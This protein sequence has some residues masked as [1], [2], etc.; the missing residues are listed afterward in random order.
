MQKGL[1][2]ENIT[3]IDS[4]FFDQE[5]GIVGETYIVDMHLYGQLN[6]EDMI[7][8][9][10]TIK[11]DAK[12]FID[13]HLDHLF[14]V[15]KQNKHIKVQQHPSHYEVHG[16]YGP[17]DKKHKKLHY[18]APHAALTLIDS[19]HISPESLVDYL[20]QNLT[21]QLPK[22]IQKVC[23][24]LRYEAIPGPYFRYSHGLRNHQ[25]NC[26][27]LIHGHRSKMLILN[28]DQLDKEC[29]QAQCQAWQVIYLVDQH[30][31]QN[32][33]QE[34]N[35]DYLSIAY[36]AP[37]GHF[38]LS[39]PEQ[40]CQIMPKLV[41]IENIADFLY[42]KHVSLKSNTQ[43]RVYEGLQKGALCQGS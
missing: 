17:G 22:N 40:D 37:Q 32:R 10:S 20:E 43:V 1:F 35:I 39:L 8:D 26:Q 25:G 31:I 9:F 33:Y 14:L 27:R 23:Y 30:D 15:P 16:H 42:E 38:S 12:A 2:I 7:I 5:I 36:D 21:P 19:T 6:D 3:N 41:T 34:E 13:E 18:I 24:T 29:T 4:S 28:Q 11:K